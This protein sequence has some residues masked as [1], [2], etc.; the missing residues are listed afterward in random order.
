MFGDRYPRKPLTAK[1]IAAMENPDAYD[2]DT[3]E[4]LSWFDV[5]VRRRGFKIAA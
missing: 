5:E 4:L 2:E 1:Q 3:E